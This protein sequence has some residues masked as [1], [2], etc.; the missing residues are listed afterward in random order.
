LVSADDQVADRLADRGRGLVGQA[1]HDDPGMTA[2]RVGADITQ[3]DVQRD[4]HPSSGGSGG[5]HLRVGR[6]AQP[7]LAD[8]VDVV[9]GA[10]QDGSR[11]DRQVLIELEFSPRLRQRQQLL[12]RQR[13]AVS[14]R[15]AHAR[16]SDRGYSAVISSAAMPAARQS[17][18][19]LTG[20]RVP[21]MTAWPCITCG[22]AE[23]SAI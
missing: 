19:T 10:G 1:Q 6:A 7:L 11:G 8:G 21:A 15:R 4:Q 23:I 2:R 16:D 9:T 13:R 3:S 18:I 5:H 14:G 20:M 17:R 12:A 22:S